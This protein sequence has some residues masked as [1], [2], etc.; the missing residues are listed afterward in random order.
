MAD[1]QPDSSQPLNLS[2]QDLVHTDQSSENQSPPL[3]P[4]EL[5]PKPFG[6]IQKV[7]SLVFFVLTISLKA[8]DQNSLDQI[9]RNMREVFLYPI[10]D[11]F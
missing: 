5:M 8:L 11:W 7:C 6:N 3:P 10:Q 4:G 2:N 1:S 9:Q